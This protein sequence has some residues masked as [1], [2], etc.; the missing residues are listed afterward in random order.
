MVEFLQLSFSYLRRRLHLVVFGTLCNAQEISPRWHRV[1][2]E[3][4]CSSENS[5]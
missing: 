5:V 2:R 4:L 1:K 3:R